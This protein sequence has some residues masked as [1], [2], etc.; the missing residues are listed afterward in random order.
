[1]I[2]FCRTLEEADRVLEV[3]ADHA[4]VRGRN[5][6]ETDVM[7]EIPSDIILAR[8]FSAREFSDRFD[9]FSIGSNDLARLTLGVDR[10]SE[11]LRALF[12][13]RDPAVTTS[14]R[15]L[16][17]TAHLKGRKV[18]LCGRRPGDDPD[19]ARL[20]VDAAAARV[21]TRVSARSASR[22]H[23][24]GVRHCPVPPL[25]LPSCL[26]VVVRVTDHAHR[27]PAPAAPARTVGA[28]PGGM[29]RVEV[30]RRSARRCRG[31]EPPVAHPR[32]DMGRR[33]VF[34]R[35]EPPSGERQAT[36]RARAGR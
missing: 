23:V 3:M 13:E 16:I 34:R 33:L 9:G 36:G 7:A 14:I 4:L 26:P 6:L 15:T 29:R 25:A 32:R 28:V 31:T 24:G 2:P 1:M 27:V 11:Q 17:G 18:G 10:D 19:F 12:N 22:P 21:A 5:D 8:E 35:E 20:L 30:S